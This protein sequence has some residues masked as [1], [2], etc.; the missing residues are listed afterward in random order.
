MLYPE[1]SYI[2]RYDG[3]QQKHYQLLNY[4]DFEYNLKPKYAKAATM[5]N[6]LTA[7]TNYR[8]SIIA[9][10]MTPPKTSFDIS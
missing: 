10:N 5:K 2:S 4:L 7:V 1:A 9:A 3:S 8:L 6:Q